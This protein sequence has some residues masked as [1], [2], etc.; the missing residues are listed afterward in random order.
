MFEAT[1][2]FVEGEEHERAAPARSLVERELSQ[3]R[4]P[5]EPARGMGARRLGCFQVIG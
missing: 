1:R 2:M 5:L 4:K 3:Y